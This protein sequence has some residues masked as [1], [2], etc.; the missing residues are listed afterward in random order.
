MGIHHTGDPLV[1]GKPHHKRDPPPT[2]GQAPTEGQPARNGNPHTQ[3]VTTK[4]KL[5]DIWLTWMTSGLTK[6]KL[7]TPNIVNVQKLVF[8]QS[9]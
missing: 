5:H 8:A 1:K 2:K 7:L 6:L 4:G 3:G 9:R